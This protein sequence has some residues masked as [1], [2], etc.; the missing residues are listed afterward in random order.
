MVK[1]FMKKNTF[2]IQI[3]ILLIVSLFTFSACT[4]IDNTMQGG[5]FVKPQSV[6]ELQ[7]LFQTPQNTNQRALSGNMMEVSESVPL[8]SS[9][10]SQSSKDFSQTNVQVQG[11]DEA[12]II[13]TDG[14]Y[15]YTITDKTLFIIQSD[16]AEDAKVIAQYNMSSQPISLFIH[17]DSLYVIGSEHLGQSFFSDRNFHIMPTYRSFTTIDILDISQKDKPQKI[18][19]YKTQGN[20]VQARLVDEHIYIITQMSPDVANPLPIMFGGVENPVEMSISL[21]DVQYDPQAED[22]QSVS[23]HTF[24]VQTH[25][26]SVDVFFID[27][28]NHFYM[29]HSA[30]YFAS[31]EHI[32]SYE[33]QQEILK[34]LLKPYVG[35]EERDLIQRIQETESDILSQY[36][37]EAKIMQVY[38]ELSLELD[39]Q[40][41]KKIEEEMQSRYRTYIE[42]LE[43][44]VFTH[45][46][47]FS[48]DKTDIS[49][50]ANT[51]IAGRLHNQ[52]AMDEYDGVFRVVATI[53]QRWLPEV[54]ENSEVGDSIMP[55]PI[56]PQSRDS[57][58]PSS[59]SVFTFDS[60]MNKLDSVSGI[61]ETES[62]FATR[63]VG[64]TL[65]MV[66][67]EEIDPF[68]VINLADPQNI[69]IEGEL[70]IPGY[71]R[72]LHPYSD[73]IVIGIGQE[74]DERGQ[75]VGLKISLFDVE[76][77]Q[78]PRE[79]ATYIG[80]DSRAYSSVLFEHK[81][82]LLDKNR[83]RLVI[84]VQ[85]QDW[86]DSSQNYAGAL[87]FEITQDDV[88]LLGLVSHSQGVENIW[89]FGVERSLYIGDVLYTKSPYLLRANDI[90][91]LEDLKRLRLEPLS[92]TDIV[93]Y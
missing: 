81:A 32:Q 89:Q 76:D 45:I 74:V 83:Q 10:P 68:F 39:T 12:D 20:Y 85:N 53:P 58:V 43:S 92:Q 79:I 61:A 5:D 86:R 35:S 42:E 46:Q 7:F 22:I 57:S 31:T 56:P 13:K 50:V 19:S 71:S 2:K 38:H 72:Y 93:V 82:F 52:F 91:T 70:K 40:T 80:N 34:E 14:E 29:S 6:E 59:N 1:L 15:I 21:D 25:S 26:H 17:D 3:Y 77:V 65:Y 63:Y 8:D 51:T 4:Q 18:D 88:S 28:V 27:R 49:P 37:K 73:E 62:I 87:V 44:S 16:S 90:N 67:F 33:V 23:I 11:I 54:A 48:Y 24:D 41:Q 66:T 36:E 30:I 55:R 60:Q 47:K 75:T 78:N 64:E 9:A 69:L 84:P